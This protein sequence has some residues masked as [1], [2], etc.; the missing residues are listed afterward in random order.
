LWV[1]LWY[2]L[3][4]PSATNVAV[5]Q[6]ILIAPLGVIGTWLLGRRLFGPA[7][8]VGAAAIVAV[9]PLVWEFYGLLYPET[10]AVP[11]ALLLYYLFL[12]RPPTARL[13]VAVGAVVGIS[14]LVRPTSGLFFAGILAAWVIASGWKRGIG[15]TALAGAIAVLVIAP[16][17]IRNYVVADDF[18][19]I[20]LQDI[21]AY[22]TFNDEAASD[23]VHPWAWRPILNEPP[24]VLAGP[25]VD[26]A[27][28]RDGLQEYAF[29]YIR[30]HPTSVAKAFFWN[31]L[32][33]TWD[34]RRPARSIDEAPFEGR[35]R[36]LAAIGLGMYWVMLGLTL[37]GLWRIRRRTSLVVPLLAMALAASIV[38]TVGAAT[39]Y[40]APFEPLFAILAVSALVPWL[41]PAAAEPPA[42]EPAEPVAA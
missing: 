8:G 31:G 34:V 19:P 16:W 29:D 35:S 3:L 37:V 6:A 10:M 15:M 33:R 32:V 27:T 23:P 11:L 24:A 26:D 42:R 14:M 18:I 9:L 13:A 1:G 7:V 30:E 28:L 40:R 21:A 2:V 12:E 38:F 20:S 25:P 39:R 5:V 17:T 36:T 4:G 22:G 41:R